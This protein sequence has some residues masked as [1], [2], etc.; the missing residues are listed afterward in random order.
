M[1]TAADMQ[2][3]QGRIDVEEGA[4][5]RRWHQAMQPLAEVSHP[6]LALLGFACDA[7][8]ARNHGRVGARHGPAALRAALCN[9]PLH[10]G[11]QLTD[12]GDV[13]CSAG[14]SNDGLEAAQRELANAVTELLRSGHRP[15]VLGGGH[16]MAF[17]T[18]GGLAQFLGERDAAPRIGVLNLD[19]H[20]DL[21]A[22]ASASSGTPF[23]QIA[24]DC[25]RRGWPFHYAC[26]GVSRFA[27]TEALFDRAATLGVRWLLDE[28]MTAANTP[29]TNALVADFLDGIDHLYL[30]ICLDVLPAAMAP[31]VSA[32]AARGVT[33]E[34]IEPLIDLLA[35]SGK[36]RCA[37]VA[38][39]NPQ[40]D[41][42]QRTARVAAR[43]IARLAERWSTP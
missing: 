10:G 2:A 7:G 41:I 42:D 37:D 20:F 11:L 1:R 14:K 40:Y 22:G 15:I 38:E 19:A 28:Q 34:V 31:G 43:L 23:R 21:R 4:A 39:L 24:E 32:P 8:V 33:L 30:T 27:N 35:A 12:A 6:A 36:L 9:M 3:W 26:L 17:G 18:Y 13:H 16:E 29:Q 25:Q 5:G